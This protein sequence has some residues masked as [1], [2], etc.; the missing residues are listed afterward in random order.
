MF[1][2]VCGYAKH[3]WMG[4]EINLKLGSCQFSMYISN[5]VDT[6]IIFHLICFLIFNF[7]FLFLFSSI[8][9]FSYIIMDFM[10][11]VIGIAYAFCTHGYL[12]YI[13]HLQMKNLKQAT[14][15]YIYK[16]TFI[17][18]WKIYSFSMELR[19]SNKNV[20]REKKHNFQQNLRRWREEKLVISK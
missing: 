9:Q 10:S 20:A 4:C 2:C 6:N 3:L 5:M 8:F 19:T 12:T 7:L 13:S 14:Y 11:L 1:V 17:R 15:T 18:L 16:C